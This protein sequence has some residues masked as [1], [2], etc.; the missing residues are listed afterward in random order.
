MTIRENINSKILGL[1]FE[2][3][4]VDNLNKIY[5]PNGV[6]DYTYKTIHVALGLRPD[7][8]DNVKDLDFTNFDVAIVDQFLGIV[9]RYK[10]NYS[11]N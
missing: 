10:L 11:S 5:I 2:N 9:L 8:E 7:Q 6:V 1:S 4:A 3:A